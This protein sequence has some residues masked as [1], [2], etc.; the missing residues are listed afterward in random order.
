[1]L[2]GKDFVMITTTVIQLHIPLLNQVIRIKTKN[3]DFNYLF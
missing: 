1:M 2:R 3:N